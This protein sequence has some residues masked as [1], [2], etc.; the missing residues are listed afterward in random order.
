MYMPNFYAEEAV[1]VDCKRNSVDNF[2]RWRLNIMPERD[3]D[4]QTDRLYRTL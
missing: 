2:C 1:V 3:M 4:R